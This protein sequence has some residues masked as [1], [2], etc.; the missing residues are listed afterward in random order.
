GVSVNVAS[1]DADG[2]AGAICQEIAVK[3]M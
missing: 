1:G 3:L 2:P